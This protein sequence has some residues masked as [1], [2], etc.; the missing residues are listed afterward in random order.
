M[1]KHNTHTASGQPNRYWQAVA[2]NMNLA[3]MS[4]T[5][6]VG[7]ALPSVSSTLNAQSYNAQQGNDGQPDQTGDF[8][9]GA[10]SGEAYVD[11][12]LLCSV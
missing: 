2:P 8:V 12:P 7:P 4:P 9:H 6:P 11:P 5:Q 1:V 3:L 10:S